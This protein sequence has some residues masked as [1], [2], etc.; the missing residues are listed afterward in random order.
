[1]RITNR[2]TSGN[3]IV[4]CAVV[5]FIVLII[6][7]WVLDI[8]WL[9]LLS[10]K[11]MSAAEK[12]AMAAAV[13]LNK[14][15][16]IGQMNYVLAHSRELL[17]CSRYDEATASETHKSQL[18]LAQDLAARAKQVVTILEKER[19]TLQNTRMKESIEAAKNAIASA[20]S[21]GSATMAGISTT[22]VSLDLSQCSFGC[23]S[24]DGAGPNGEVIPSNIE[25][26]SFSKLGDA[27]K[28]LEEYDKEFVDKQAKLYKGNTVLGMNPPGGGDD[29]ELTIK[30]SSLPPCINNYISPPHLIQAS[31]FNK[32]SPFEENALCT[33]IPTAVQIVLKLDVKETQSGKSSSLMAPGIA[34]TGGA[35][36]SPAKP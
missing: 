5:G 32:M 24:K 18:L 23:L 21:P 35:S 34:V 8:F 4:I 7:L 12:V 15:D 26:S 33:Y 6:G 28:D 22:G 27:G 25:P 17:Y 1:M 13:A 16:N 14:D 10:G 36:P 29:T 31:I 3:I 11:E 20:G 9:H 19:S 30:L 2:S